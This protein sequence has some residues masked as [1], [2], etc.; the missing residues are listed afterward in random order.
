MRLIQILEQRLVHRNRQAELTA[1]FQ[2]LGM[3]LQ[4]ASAYDPAQPDHG[5]SSA[6][7]A[8]IGIMNFLAVL[9]PQSDTL[10]I[11][12]Q[13]LLQG[14]V[15][16][17]RGTVIPLLAPADLRG[18]PPTPFSDELLRGLAAAAMTLL[19]E[20]GVMA[21][22]EAA[23]EIARRLNRLGYGPDRLSAVQVSKWRE[24]MMTAYVREDHA[25]QRY[26]RALKAVE[27][28]EPIPAVKVLLESLRTLHPAKFPKKGTI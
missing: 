22:K 13:D 7:I 14:L 20:R 18:R 17:D 4:M 21:R 11:A 6:K 15:D 1:A 2:Q 8:L 9:S 28:R 26:Q 10:P 27:G 5:R 3:M 25:A 23:E 16:L 12:L 19:M 24:A